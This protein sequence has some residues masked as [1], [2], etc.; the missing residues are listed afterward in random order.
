VTIVDGK[1]VKTKS[2]PTNDELLKFL[3]VPENYLKAK[4]TLEVKDCGCDDGCC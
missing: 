4:K 2:Y 1:I 3:S